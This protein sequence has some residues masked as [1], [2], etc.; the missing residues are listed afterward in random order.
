MKRNEGFT[1]IEV[2]I[3]ASLLAGLAYAFYM[4]QSLTIKSVKISTD[5]S[6][7]VRAL[8][9]VESSVM[10]DMR[11]IP[12]QNAVTPDELKKDSIIF[13]DPN[14]AGVRCYDRLGNEIV[15][16]P[17]DAP[18]FVNDNGIYYRVSFFKERIPDGSVDVASPLSRIPVTR[19]RFKVEFKIEFRPQ[20]PMYL[21]RLQTGIL[22]Y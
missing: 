1:L 7:L 12:P 14:R 9:R 21:S 19:V 22:R 13:T 18:G 5:S 20:D 2:I 15:T 16:C 10:E 8:K 17:T 4:F 11:Y 6:D 3:A